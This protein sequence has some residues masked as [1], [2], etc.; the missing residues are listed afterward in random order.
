MRPLPFSLLALALL[1]PVYASAYDY[2][3]KDPYYATITTAL[4]KADHLD[5]SLKYEDI[6]LK[7]M[8]ERD[9]VPF[10]GQGRNKIT[11]RLWTTPTDGPLMIMIAG[12]GGASSTGYHNFLAS[13]FVKKGFHV[14]VLPSP[15]HFSFALAGSSSG[16]PGLTRGDAK[17]L[18]D[19]IE[20]GVEKSRKR[21][22]FQ[23]KKIALL[24]VSMGALQTAYLSEID[25]REKRL[26]FQKVLMIN[27]PVNPLSSAAAIDGLAAK[28]D[29]ISLDARKKLPEKVVFFGSKALLMGDIKSPTYF[30][31]IESA[32]PTT[33]EERQFLIGSSMKDFL[34]A[35]I[36]AT[37][38]VDDLG[39]L[40]TPIVGK[41][42]KERLK[43]SEN[44]SFSDYLEKFFL[45]GLG[46]KLGRKLT[47]S[48]LE[49]DVVLSGVE[50]HLRS[51]ERIFLMH[52]EDDFIVDKN[53]LEY[54]RSVFGERMTIYA[55][56]G[57][58]GNV[59]YPENL[60]AVLKLFAPLTK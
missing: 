18:Y 41:D 51:N 40:K 27:P 16:Y 47:L 8:P 20:A 6:A 1:S 43:E 2:P 22:G 5:K 15:F 52:N 33:L 7:L 28:G 48:E 30:E 54:L 11:A 21:T 29:S 14:L 49:S 35:L 59:W 60:E 9:S 31:G 36:F 26:D 23:L 55:H 19:A 10:F 42:A 57:H 58:L 3:Y 25:S 4:L 44:F 37:Q 56:G 34:S 46:K 17:D 45:P 50:S 13:Q 24:G 12:L 32:L 53:E 38:Q 39:V